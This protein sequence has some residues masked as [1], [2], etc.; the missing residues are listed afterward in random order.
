MSKLERLIAESVIPVLRFD[1]TELA[2]FAVDAVLAAGFRSVELT[3]TIPNVLKL[4]EGVRNTHGTELLLGVGTVLNIQQAEDALAAGAD[5]VVSPCLVPGVTA[6]VNARGGLSMVG[7]YTPGEVYAAL[8]EKPEVI[9]VFP[10][11]SG[12]PS[13]I[14]ALK[15]I[16]PQA[17]LCPTGGVA[18]DNM[19]DFLRAGASFVGIGN[20]LLD[21]QALVQRDTARVTGAARRCREVALAAARSGRGK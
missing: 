5:F 14:A 4:V 11:S 15:S 20:S 12:G 8:A 16:F 10:A 1:D 13:H 18:L 9:K 2:R 3:Y 19:A 17:V 6:R 21:Q 7:A